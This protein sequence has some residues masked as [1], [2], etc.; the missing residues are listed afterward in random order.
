MRVTSSSPHTQLFIDTVQ[1]LFTCQH[2]M[3]LT[4][5]RGDDTPHLV[6]TNNDNMIENLKYLPSLGSSDHLCISFVWSFQFA[7]LLIRSLFSSTMCIVP[8]IP[9]LL[10]TINWEC[11]MENLSVNGTWH[12]F[13]TRL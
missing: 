6:F 8:I 2:V 1:D 3:E 9:M 4:K 13:S 7:R 11:D 10:S 5:F 12:F